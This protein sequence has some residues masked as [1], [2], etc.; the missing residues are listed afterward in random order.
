MIEFKFSCPNCGQHIHCNE[1]YSRMQISCPTCKN[2]I[3]VPQAPGSI[4]VNPAMPTPPSPPLPPQTPAAPTAIAPT[5]FTVKEKSKTKVI[6]VCSAAVLI[7]AAVVAYVILSSD[8]TNSGEDSTDVINKKSTVQK[9]AVAKKSKREE[10]NQAPIPG[11]RDLQTA[12]FPQNSKDSRTLSASEIVRNVVEQYESLTSYSASGKSVSIIDMSEVDPSNIPGMSGDKSAP[13]KTSEE[14]KKAMSKPQRMESE[15]SV[16]LAKPDFYR[17]EWQGQT[18]LAQSKG[19]AWSSGDGDFLFLDMGQTK[20]A[21]MKTRELALAS[22]TGLSG[23]VANTMPQI[24]FRGSAS[25]LNLFKN[26][27]RGDD[28]TIDGK[29]CFV[30]TGNAMGLKVLLWIDKSN[31]LIKQKQQV[32]GGNLEMPEMSEDKMEEGIKQIGGKPNAA[33]KAQMK[34][35]MKNARA[36][37]SQMKGT[38]TETYQHIEINKPVSKDEFNYEVPAGT[39]LSASLF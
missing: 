35:A 30:L 28:A 6:V 5:L 29:D 24:F 26:A 8:V 12:S 3:I 32:L 38:M 9:S 16:K 1:A 19:A 27:T 10:S 4:P 34:D 33:Q 22:A 36:L 23:G 39:K 21:R 18:G 13:G 20:Y 37:T 14:F 25:L 15:F 31:Y 2:Q 7:F 11:S 17:V